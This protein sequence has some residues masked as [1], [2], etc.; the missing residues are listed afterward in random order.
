[1]AN[2]RD[3]S[4]DVK[5]WAVDAPSQATLFNLVQPGGDDHWRAITGRH[6]PLSS[7]GPSVRNEST[8]PRFGDNSC[9]QVLDKSGQGPAIPQGPRV[10]ASR[11]LHPLGRTEEL[12]ARSKRPAPPGDVPLA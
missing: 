3:Y 11:I 9:P 10:S 5:Y 1:M 7:A 12:R 4:C 6:K 8:C 2:R